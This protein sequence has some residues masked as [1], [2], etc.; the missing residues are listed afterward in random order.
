MASGCRSG[1]P[2]FIGC[3]AGTTTLC[4]SR[5]Y[6]RS[7]QGL[8]IWLPCAVIFLVWVIFIARDWGYILLSLDI[9]DVE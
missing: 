3:W 5:L 8:R 7:S 2:G 1:P 4:H 6:A 9:G